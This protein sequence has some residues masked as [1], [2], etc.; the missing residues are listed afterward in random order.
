MVGAWCGRG[1]DPGRGRTRTE[2]GG[3]V[4]YEGGKKIKGR[5]QHI[6]VD[7]WGLLLVVAVTAGNLDDGT[8]VWR[9][10]EKLTGDKFPRL[11]K[12]YGDNKYRNTSFDEWMVIHEVG[13]ELEI[14]MKPG[15][16]KGF[17]P[18]RIRW[19]VEQSHACLGRCRRLSKDYERLTSSSETWI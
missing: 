9:V 10:L 8:H 13:Y 3:D 18:I 5:K 6:V 15:G 17:R 7:T 1:F 2:I 19:V 4:G 11:K 12:I 16:E 14:G